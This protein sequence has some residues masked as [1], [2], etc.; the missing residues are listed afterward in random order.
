MSSHKSSSLGLAVQGFIG[1]LQFI[2]QM[3]GLT[4]LHI[5]AGAIDALSCEI[6]YGSH[7]FARGLKICFLL[8]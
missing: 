8:T 4:E 7:L 3:L 6:C 1:L 5:K 2:K